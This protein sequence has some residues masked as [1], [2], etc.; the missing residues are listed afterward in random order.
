MSERLRVELPDSIVF[1][2]GIGVSSSP[3]TETL[4]QWRE[5]WN[6]GAGYIVIKTANHERSTTI[7]VQTRVNSYQE[8]NLTTLENIG[9]T[10]IEQKPI[11]EL[12]D[13]IK[14]AREEGI[15]V[16]PSIA[17]KNSDV[18]TWQSMIDAV[19]STGVPYLESTLRYPYRGI[20][21][22]V[23]EELRKAYGYFEFECNEYNVGITPL[24]IC[25]RAGLDLR[26]IEKETNRRF[27]AFLHSLG[28]YSRQ[29]GV[30]MIAK[31]WGGRHDIPALVATCALAG[32]KGVTLVNSFQSPPLMD[33]PDMQEY[34]RANVSGA[35]L[36]RIRNA[37]L[38][39]A[40]KTL[41][42]PTLSKVILLASGGVAVELAARDKQSIDRALEDVVLCLELGAD[43]V[44]LYTALHQ[45][46]RLLGQLVYALD[47]KLDREDKT[48]E[49]L[50]QNR[51]QFAGRNKPIYRLFRI[52]QDTCIGCG[53]CEKTS[54][55]DAI[56]PTTKPVAAHKNLTTFEIHPNDCTGCGLCVTVCPVENTIVP[57]YE[58]KK[59]K[60]VP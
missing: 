11:Y 10:S 22:Q 18:S 23:V 59:E 45:D 50:K 24:T 60:H 5:L 40:N 9:K 20:M 7:S 54:Y 58:G 55:C 49:E 44:Q 13:E 14:I 33:F 39:A 34:K 32:M 28:D 57:F 8:G 42:D 51:S 25:E 19:A 47:K 38:E 4:H 53:L 48:F 1:R 15:F 31:L 36:R 16:I 46:Q 41:Q 17:S 6:Y 30:G 26:Y 21:K 27:E 56:W 43:M 37:A 52:N 35:D 2:N 3:V 12:I 29:K